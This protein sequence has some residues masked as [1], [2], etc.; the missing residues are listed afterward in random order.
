MR[1]RKKGGRITTETWKIFLSAIF[2]ELDFSKHV[3]L[4]AAPFPFLGIFVLFFCQASQMLQRMM[5]S[6]AG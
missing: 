5:N 2:L 3:L 6:P 1:K 4:K